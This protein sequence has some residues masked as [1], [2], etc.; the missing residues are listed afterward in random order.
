MHTV[1]IALPGKNEWKIVPVICRDP[2]GVYVGH[3]GAV[4]LEGSLVLIRYFAGG[5]EVRKVARH[6]R[7]AGRYEF[8]QMAEARPAQARTTT[9]RKFAA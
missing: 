7:L 2:R 3:L 8:I 9:D 5:Q 4:G 1:E 6:G